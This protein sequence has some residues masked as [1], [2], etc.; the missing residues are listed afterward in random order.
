MRARYETLRVR[1]ARAAAAT[2]LLVL[3][4]PHASPAGAATHT[5]PSIVMGHLSVNGG[6]QTAGSS[7]PAGATVEAAYPA[8][9]RMPD[10]TLVALQP[11]AA[12]VFAGNNTAVSTPNGNDDPYRIRIER[13]E[14]SLDASTRIPGARPL[15]YQLTT[16]LHTVISFLALQGTVVVDGGRE[17]VFCERCGRGDFT[18]RSFDNSMSLERS[19]QVALVTAEGGLHGGVI[20]KSTPFAT[21]LPP[22]AWPRFGGGWAERS[23][24]LSVREAGGDHPKIVPCPGIPV[25]MRVVGATPPIS[26]VPAD[27][28]A[29]TIDA[30]ATS[31]S[32][33]LV[34]NG[35]PTTISLTDALGRS[36]VIES[37]PIASPF[38]SKD[39]PPGPE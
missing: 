8:V 20:V 27:V 31:E 17:R 5:M 35:A 2:A 3:L 37:A 28:S 23:L 36:A 13:G 4:T 25:T 6:D 18:V 30:G 34:A 12:A 21:P 19:G 16:P 15:R 22:N 33:R 24:V 1:G 26:I 11:N 9:V 38:C 29:A 32:F 7:I 14:L 39:V 10:G